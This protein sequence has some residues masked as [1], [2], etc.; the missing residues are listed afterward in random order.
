MKKLLFIAGLLFFCTVNAFAGPS[1]TKEHPISFDKD[2]KTVSFLAEVNGK[3]LYQETRHFAVYE[4][5]S[6]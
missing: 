2:K 5:G 3:Y 4:K 1:L 6:N